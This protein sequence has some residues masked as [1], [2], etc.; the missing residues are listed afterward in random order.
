MARSASIAGPDTDRSRGPRR[1]LFAGATPTRARASHRG[2][3]RDLPCAGRPR[4]YC[5]WS[6][7]MKLLFFDDFRLGVLHGD[8][9]VDVSDVVKDIPHLE[10]QDLISGLIERFDDYR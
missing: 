10:P 2:R 9:V 1:L 4:D 5:A 6:V 8:S 3:S 7:R